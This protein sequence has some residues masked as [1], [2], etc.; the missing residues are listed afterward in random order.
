MVSRTGCQNTDLRCSKSEIY[1]ADQSGLLFQKLPNCT[2][3]YEGE[4]KD[5]KGTKRMADKSRITIMVCTAASGDQVPM[6]VVGK[7]K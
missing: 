6:A 4:K 7:F 3:L 1:N 5:A 2:Y